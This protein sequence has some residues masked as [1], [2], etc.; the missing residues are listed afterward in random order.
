MLKHLLVFLGMVGSLVWAGHRLYYGPTHYTHLSQ[1]LDGT[2]YHRDYG[3]VPAAYLDTKDHVLLYF[4]ASWCAACQ[5]VTPLLIQFYTTYASHQNFEI[6]LVS[7][8][9][10]AD[11]LHAYVR[12]AAI[13]WAS[14]PFRDRQ[15]RHTFQDWYGTSTI[16]HLVLLDKR[17]RELASSVRGGAYVGPLPVLAALQHR[18][19]AVSQSRQ[20]RAAMA[21]AHGP[22]PGPSLGGAF[23]SEEDRDVAETAMLERLRAQKVPPHARGGHGH[24]ENLASARHVVHCLPRIGS[25][26]CSRCLLLPWPTALC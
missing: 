3:H 15:A 8:D 17:G 14:I 9:R 2:V 10:S 6:L 25:R 13:P 23:T 11:A 4:A 22:R 21:S 5:Q 7:D 12:R 24:T 20:A 19:Q 1:V 26:P 16:P 18:W